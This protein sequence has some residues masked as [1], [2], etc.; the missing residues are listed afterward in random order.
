MGKT[1]AYNRAGGHEA[2]MGLRGWVREE[3]DSQPGLPEKKGPEGVIGEGR[4]EE[5]GKDWG[6][7]QSRWT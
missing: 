4:E 2:M 5:E 3:R 1:G 6:L 7:Q